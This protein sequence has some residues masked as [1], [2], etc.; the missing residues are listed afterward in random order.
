[1]FAIFDDSPNAFFENDGHCRT[2]HGSWETRTAGT[3]RAADAAVFIGERA[4]DGGEKRAE[5]IFAPS[6]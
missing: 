6:S 1:M 2:T 5:S 3:S 4:D